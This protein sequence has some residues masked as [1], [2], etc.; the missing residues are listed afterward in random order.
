MMIT[1]TSNKPLFTIFSNERFFALEK[2][3]RCIL[4]CAMRLFPPKVIPKAFIVL[5]FTTISWLERSLSNWIWHPWTVILRHFTNIIRS[6]V[7]F[8]KM[9]WVVKLTNLMIG[10]R[11]DKLLTIIGLFFVPSPFQ[12]SS[13]IKESNFSCLMVIW[14]IWGKFLHYLWLDF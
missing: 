3:F 14:P 13:T 8:L 9:M 11:L 2:L 6:I 5:H 12:P 1:T 4:F 7:R 10:G